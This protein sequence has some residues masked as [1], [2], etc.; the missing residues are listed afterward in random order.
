MNLELV[1]RGAASAYFFRRE[2]GRYADDLLAAARRAVLEG[3]G[4]WGAC[5]SARLDPFRGVDS[6]RA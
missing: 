4:L 3:L 5:P 6:G 1:R 2:E